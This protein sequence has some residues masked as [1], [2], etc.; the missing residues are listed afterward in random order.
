MEPPLSH[1][2]GG[3]PAPAMQTVS[4]PGTAA[5]IPYRFPAAD[6]AGIPVSA[7]PGRGGSLSG[8]PGAG[9]SSALTATER[10]NTR[11]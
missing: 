11:V 7:P 8:A 9:T 5:A 1:R 3:V 6:A 10:R 4:F 2:A